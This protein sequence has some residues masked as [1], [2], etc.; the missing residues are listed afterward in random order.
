M[1]YSDF[2]LE[3]VKLIFQI[4]TIENSNI[5]VDI[6]ELKAGQLLKET[7]EILASGINHNS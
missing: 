7:L 4:N 2:S 5:F 1:A 3:T 6:P